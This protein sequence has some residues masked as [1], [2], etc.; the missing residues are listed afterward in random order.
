MSNSGRGD[1]G[2]TLEDILTPNERAAWD[3][4]LAAE[5]ELEAARRVVIETTNRES[6]HRGA[7]GQPIVRR[8]RP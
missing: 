1:C 6:P 3:R 2:W 5:V 4:L 8:A 7:P